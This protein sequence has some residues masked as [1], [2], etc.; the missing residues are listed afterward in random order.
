MPT[1]VRQPTR[2]SPEEIAT[3]NL[4]HWPAKPWCPHCVAGRGRDEVHKSIAASRV[5]AVQ[6]LIMCDYMFTAD[7]KQAHDHLTGV[8][9]SDTSGGGVWASIVPGKGS[10]LGTYG[11]S[12]ALSFLR[13]TGH[14]KI[15]LQVDG[16]PA[17]ID[18]GTQ[19]CK[20]ANEKANI[21]HAS[22]QV[23]PVASHASNGAAERAIGFRRG[24][25]RVL[26]HVLATVIGEPISPTSPWW[27]WAV[28]HSAWTCNRFH[29]K[30]TLGQ[31]TPYEKYRGKRYASPIAHFGASV[32]ARRP[33][34]AL[35]KA[36]PPLLHSVWLGRDGMT[37]EH[38]VA[39]N[40]GVFR[41][42]TMRRKSADE[43]WNASAIKGMR[44]TPWHTAD[45]HRGRPPK[46]DGGSE[47]VLAAPLPRDERQHAFPADG[48]QPSVTSMPAPAAAM[49]PPAADDPRVYPAGDPDSAACGPDPTHVP[50]APAATE[51]AAAAA[52]STTSTADTSAKRARTSPAAGAPQGLST[53][54]STQTSLFEKPPSPRAAAAVRGPSQ[55]PPGHR[56]KTTFNPSVNL[57]LE[58]ELV[59]A[60]TQLCDE[61]MAPVDSDEE[62]AKA[63]RTHVDLLI[64]MGVFKEVEEK[65]IMSKPLSSRWVDRTHKYPVKSRL[66]VRGYEQ[67]FR[68]E[69]HHF[70]S[71]TPGTTTLR[72]F[73]AIAA[74]K[75]WLVAF[76]DADHAFLQSMLPLDGPQFTCV[77]RRML[78]SSSSTS[79]SS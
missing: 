73:L 61:E 52:P 54:S 72:V 53:A 60:L 18:F 20:Q 75:K 46:Q 4:T 29:R 41:T 14:I 45:A 40:A 71:A 55:D 62:L 44:W 64:R 67:S 66:T 24:H 27:C 68:D 36:G 32:M 21:V 19:V 51:T 76:G 28:R 35:N 10:L 70:F 23:S 43:E 15:T 37:D 1:A 49:A 77:H 39:T 25:S 22:L 48:P 63:R 58:R 74:F 2:P 13:E 8:V 59:H 79:G 42:R 69:S 34:A 7:P 31:L 5:D 26:L 12:S 65:S 50:S 33:G 57:V 56:A 17:L 16:E 9:F 30:A 38:I 6:A 47:P 11:I 3:H 78:I